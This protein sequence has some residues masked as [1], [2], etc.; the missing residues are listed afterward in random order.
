MDHRIPK[1]SWQPEVFALWIACLV[2]TGL[3]WSG[4]VLLAEKLWQ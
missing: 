4:V 1:Q 3:F 2:F